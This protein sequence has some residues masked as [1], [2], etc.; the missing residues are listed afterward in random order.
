MADSL[1]QTLSQGDALGWRS[2][3][4]WAARTLPPINPCIRAPGPLARRDEGG[5]GPLGAY[6]TNPAIG[7]A[8]YIS[9]GRPS[10]SVQ[11]AWRGMPSVSKIVAARFSVVWRSLTGYAA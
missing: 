3:A 1:L 8:R 7:S 6:P 10:R 11:V 5:A 4:L 9:C 2:Q